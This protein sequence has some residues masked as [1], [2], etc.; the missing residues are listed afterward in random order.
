MGSREVRRGEGAYLA[1]SIEDL[2]DVLCLEPYRHSSVQR[3]LGQQVLV[4][5]RG[6]GPH[7]TDVSL[8]AATTLAGLPTDVEL[9]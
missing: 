4:D 6:S 9:D 2:D 8:L 5:E 7:K 3:V 1:Q